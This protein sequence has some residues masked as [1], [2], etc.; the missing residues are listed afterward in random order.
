MRS[1]LDLHGDG[2]AISNMPATN[3]DRMLVNSESV[4][5]EDDAATK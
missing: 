5:I 3:S 4:Q 2:S 1:T